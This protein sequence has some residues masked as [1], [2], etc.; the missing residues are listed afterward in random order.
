[1]QSER[2]RMRTK[3]AFGVGAVAEAGT[4][5][6]FNTFNFLFYNNVL[7]LSGTLCGLAVT[8]ALVLDA[9]NDPVIGFMS[10]RWKSKLGRRHPFL[11]AAPIPVAISFYCIYSP[12]AGLSEFSLFLWFTA[13]T[14]LFRQSM[15]LYHVPHL[16]LGAELSNDYH[17][18]S[19]VMSYNAIFQVIGGA[20]VFFFGWTYFGK[21]EGGTSSRAAYASLALVIALLSATIIFLSAQ[22]TR[23]QIARLPQPP[24]NQPKATLRGFFHETFACLKNKNY[25][26]LLLGLLCLSA[27]IGTRETLGS[28]MSLF[29]WELPETKIRLFGLA[30]PPAYIIAFVLTVRLHR[31]FEKRAAI[32]GS[33]IVM[34]FAA[35]TPII[36]RMLG[37]FPENGSP[38]L[39][40]AL[41]FFHFVFYLGIAV[42][43]IS[44]LS[45]LADIADD[46]ELLTGRRQEGMF[47]AARTFFAQLSSGLGHLVAGLAIDI[48]QFPKGAKPGTI[49]DNV[50]F[51]LGLIDGP[52]AS[53]PAV[54][55]LF[56]YARYSITKRRHAE[57]Q[58]ELAARRVP[59]P[60]EPAVVPDAEPIP[61]AG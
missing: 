27:A 38:T 10:D 56:F 22:G 3:L 28:Y 40:P 23:D 55:A 54:I 25:S 17:E 29:F 9:I 41:L 16:A 57:I 31:W 12:P 14:L 24:A 1:M 43:T 5:I 37:A 7:G 20:S 15:S 47:F 46:H 18:R 13:F 58:R 59:R 21:V 44:V 30:S 60:A 19:I 35:S 6:A 39:L 53:V 42:L 8:I 4:Y 49:P 26:N 45:A 50:V 48:I 52:I 61:F 51:E 33:G 34:V 32:I 36:A 11:Y 2:L